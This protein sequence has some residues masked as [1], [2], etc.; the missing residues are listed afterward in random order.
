MLRIGVLGAGAWGTAVAHHIA[1]N[2]HPVLMWANEL[3]VVDSVNKNQSNSFLAGV[4]LDQKIQATHDL[5]EFFKNVDIVFEAVPVRY[6]ENVLSQA[7]SFMTSSHQWVVMSKGIHQGLL[8]D[9]ILNN[10]PAVS[11][12]RAVLA[13]PNF[14]REVAAGFYTETLVAGSDH[15]FLKDLAHIFTSDHFKVHTSNDYYG[16]LASGAYKNVVALGVGIARGAGFHENACAALITQ[17]LV[18][19][20]NL[21]TFYEGEAATVYSLAGLGD[22][23]L[24]CGS[25][26]SRNVSFGFKIGQGET[27]ESLVKKGIERS[28][29]VATAESLRDAR[30]A[31]LTLP[32]SRRISDILFAG[33]P[34]QSLFP[35]SF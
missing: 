15:A 3:A 35:L 1:K 8:V 12:K 2:G 4:V 22:L 23:V 24:T 19:V 11:T 7:S 32:L 14:A 34:V 17:G 29:G 5:G 18:E 21:V 27:V 31:H 30:F 20:A 33:A 13:G 16:V 26:Q 28:E 10:V 25:M 9:E 6:L